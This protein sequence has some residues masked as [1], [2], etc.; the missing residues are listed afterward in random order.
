M[1]DEVKKAR[2]QVPRSMVTAVVA[3]AVM[4]FLYMMTVLFA[5]GDIERALA[6]P[7]PILQV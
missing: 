5:I 1:S 6:D 3:N 4:Q 2:V 7:L